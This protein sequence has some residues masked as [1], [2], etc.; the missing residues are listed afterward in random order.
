MMRRP[1]AVLLALLAATALPAA[2][3]VPP[4]DAP[5]DSAPDDARDRYRGQGI[6]ICIAELRAVPDLSPDDL[7][8]ICGCAIDGYLERVGA[9]PP[10]P[11]ERSRFPAAVRSQLISCTARTRP[12]RMGDVARLTLAT[13]QTPPAPPPVQTP[14]PADDKPLAEEAA[15]AE[16]GG[17]GPGDRFWAWLSGLALPAWLTGASLL[18]W[19]AIGIFVFGLLILALRRRDPRKDL[20]APPS[21]MRRGMPPVAPRRPDLPR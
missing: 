2:K 9:T 20:S 5:G 15:P 10:A 3:P 19:I 11:I 18:W 21:H 17:T 7:E 8:S 12:E 13:P 6:S 1:V 16:E 4:T 14:Q